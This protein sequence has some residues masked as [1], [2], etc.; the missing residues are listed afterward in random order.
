M[1]TGILNA[2]H[3]GSAT[4]VVCCKLPNGLIL[5][6]GFLTAPGTV[7]VSK[8]PQY[9]RVVLAG[10]N[11]QTMQHA[12][13]NNLIPVS[14]G[15]T[16]AGITVNVEEAFFDEWVKKH[17][18]SFIVKNRQIWKCKN[19]AEAQASVLDD[20]QRKTGWESRDRETAAAKGSQFEIKKFNADD[21]GEA[22]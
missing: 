6:S 1:I 9:K 12:A 15:I 7:G 4:C 16:R 5:E 17:P 11:L 18:N 13:A 10:A 20:A 2:K 8:G 19:L 3:S 21:K 14:S 22:A